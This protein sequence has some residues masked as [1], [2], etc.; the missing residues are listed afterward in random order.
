M[1]SYAS[2]NQKKKLNQEEFYKILKYVAALQ[3][4]MKFEEINSEEIGIFTCNIKESL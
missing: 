2:N 3:N 4:G 1:W